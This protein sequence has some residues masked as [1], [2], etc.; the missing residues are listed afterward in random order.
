MSSR[1]HPYK[2]QP[3]EAFWKSAVKDRHPFELTKMYTKKFE[4]GEAPIASAGSCFAQHIGRFIRKY[5]FNYLDFEPPPPSLPVPLHNHYGYGLY[6]ARYGNIYTAR[7]LVQ[8]FDRA[9]DHFSPEEK[10]WSAGEDGYVDPFRPSLEP[11]PYISVEETLELQAGHLHRVRK[12]FEECRI[13][14]FTLG[15]TEAWMHAAD[16]AVY[17]IVPGTSAGGE[18]HQNKYLLHNF[19]YPEI[20]KDLA[21]FRDKLHNINPDCKIILTVSP[22]S[23]AATG[24]KRHVITSTIY[25]KSVLRAVAG[26]FADSHEDVDYFPSYDIITSPASRM[27]HFL[28]DCRTIAGCGVEQVMRHFFR[29]HLPPNTEAA[30]PENLPASTVDLPEEDGDV[31]CDEKYFAE[32]LIHDSP[33]DD[34]AERP[35]E[36]QRLFNLLKTRD[37]QYHKLWTELQKKRKLLKKQPQMEQRK[38][39]NS[40]RK[41]RLNNPKGDESGFFNANVIIRSLLYFLSKISPISKRWR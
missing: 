34:L 31:I 41:N 28:P 9:F 3:P 2:K 37:E 5:G 38:K 18:F 22:V 25:S 35:Q 20:L 4:I 23:L 24:L 6:S 36:K 32:L 15:L 17:P 10:V 21:V 13:F 27:I 40:G 19:T 8:L 33:H 30:N 14:I 39:E 1:D 12:V 29:E 26:D 7:Q 16:G 11:K